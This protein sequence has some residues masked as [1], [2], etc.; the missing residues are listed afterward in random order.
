MKT[1]NVC[2]LIMLIM[3]VGLVVSY[4]FTRQLPDIVIAVPLISGTS[5]NAQIIEEANARGMM[6]TYENRRFEYVTTLNTT[7][8]IVIIATN[9]AL[10]FVMNYTF[11]HGRFFNE[12]AVRYNHRVAV[13]NMESAFALFRTYEA[14]GN[15][16]TIGGQPYRII[17]VV[18]DNR[19]GK[20]IYIPFSGNTVESVASGH[21]LFTTGEWQR[22]GITNERYRFIDFAALRTVIWD[23]VVLAIFILLF[24]VLAIMLRKSATLMKIQVKQIKLLLKSVYLRELYS[25]LPLWKLIGLS[26]ASLGMIIFMGFMVT[27][28]IWRI[29]IAIEAQG[30]LVGLQSA[31]F[32]EQLLEMARW[33]NASKLFFLGFVLFYALL[34]TTEIYY[35]RQ[36]A[37]QERR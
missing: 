6:F 10:P 18:N 17:G 32:A 26:V 23:K 12:Y 28:A 15:E 30:S 35:K 34:I 22:M 16:I 7:H 20:N 29:L 36:Y 1:R 13:L 9:H 27:D 19:A 4:Y 3:L 31:A 11:T 21:G 5:I 2:G 24:G 8:N 25:K 37:V 14:T 33:Y